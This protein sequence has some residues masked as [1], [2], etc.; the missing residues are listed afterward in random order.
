M[1]Q[2]QILFLDEALT[3]QSI[4]KEPALKEK[5]K[6]LLLCYSSRADKST[7]VRRNDEDKQSKCWCQKIKLLEHTVLH[8]NQ[9]LMKSFLAIFFLF[10]VFVTNTSVVSF[11]R[12][13]KNIQPSANYK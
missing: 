9:P 13:T 11:A 12:V 4:A 8:L 1:M 5:K 7:S 6:L 2:K 3:R 10:N